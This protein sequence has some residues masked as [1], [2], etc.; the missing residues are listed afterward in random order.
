MLRVP[1]KIIGVYAAH[2]FICH[3]DESGSDPGV[4]TKSKSDT[5]LLGVGG[6][7][8]HVDEWKNFE[9]EWDTLLKSYGLPYFHMTEFANLRYPY[10]TWDEA[11]RDKFIQAVIKIIN[12]NVR[13]GVVW[14]IEPDAYME[15]IKA[16]NLLDK[17]IVRAY[18]ICARKC[19]ESVALWAI[20]AEH[21]YKVLHIFDQGCSAWPTFE[22]SFTPEILDA[23]DILMP[24]AQRKTDV[25]PIQAADALV[26]QTVRNLAL[27]AGLIP[28]NSQR[29]YSYNLFAKAGVVRYID[30]PMLSRMYRTELLAE[31][32]RL[33]GIDVRRGLDPRRITPEHKR[34][35]EEIFS[36]PK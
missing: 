2:R 17:D 3:W 12:A 14:A 10:S 6:Y 22:A 36:E 34:I 31:E 1:R 23:Y 4:E 16:K 30:M 9:Q 35:A 20:V 19:I 27:S 7:L 28:P 24:T 18:H 11:K 15:V 13:K 33:S 25:T 8:A 21:P 29:L 5:P 26:H 32:L